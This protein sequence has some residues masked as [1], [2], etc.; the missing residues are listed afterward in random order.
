M[1]PAVH[2]PA[3]A[4]H[5]LVPAREGEVEVEVEAVAEVAEAAEAAQPLL[6]A[7]V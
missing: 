1:H 5:W 4:Q 7:A 2:P 6:A 3:L